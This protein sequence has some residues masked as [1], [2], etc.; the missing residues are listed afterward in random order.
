MT[1]EIILDKTD[2]INV[3]I[4]R[5]NINNYAS[6]GRKIAIAIVLRYVRVFARKRERE[7]N[8]M[9]RA[10]KDALSFR[11][12]KFFAQTMNAFKRR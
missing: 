8:R 6:C 11:V 5:N 12:I 1:R 2:L 4:E 10:S 3:A 7:T 9:I